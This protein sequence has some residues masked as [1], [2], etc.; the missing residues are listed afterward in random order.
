MVADNDY[1]VGSLVDAVSHSPIW[2]HTAIFILEDDAQNGPDHVDSHRSDS[3]VI[4]PYVKSG[5][6]SSKFYN[7]DQ[8]PPR[9]GTSAE[10]GAAHAVRRDC[11]PLRGN[12]RQRAQQ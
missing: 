10:R 9:N 6:L 7:T 8:H 2:A 4:S 3:Y 11:Q 12:L 5:V 1:A